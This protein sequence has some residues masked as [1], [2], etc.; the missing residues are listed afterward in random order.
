[1]K[2]VYSALLIFICLTL[3]G[4]FKTRL[5]APPGRDVRILSNEEP[6]AFKTEYKNWY[7]FYGLLPVWTTQPEE[8]IE[9]ERLV[10]VRAQT[11]DTISDA[12]ITT[13]SALLPI[14]V[15]PQHVILEGN[16]ESDIR[17]HKQY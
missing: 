7:L 3:S 2:I 1:M 13:L 4:C 16:R 17:V 15:F 12:I 5:T 14:L 8:I 11:Q 10:E 9:K 6:A